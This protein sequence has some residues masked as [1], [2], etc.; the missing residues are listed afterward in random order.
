MFSSLTLLFL[1]AYVVKRVFIVPASL[2]HLPR[3]SV[4]ELLKSYVSREEES[5]RVR[6]LLLPFANATGERQ[7]RQKEPVVLVWAFG[8]WI[9]HVI[10]HE[11]GKKALQDRDWV[12]DLP[13]QSLLL[14]RFVGKKNLAFTIGEEWK[15]HSRVITHAFQG[16]PPISQFVKVFKRLQSHFPVS[17]DSKDGTTVLWDKWTEQIALD[18]L[19]KAVLGHDFEAISN[20]SSPVLKN[21]RYVMEHITEP[22]YI[23]IPI[24]DRLFPRKELVQS[25]DFIRERYQDI[26]SEKVA[27][28]EK[29]EK[30]G[31]GQEKEGVIDR[32]ISNPEFGRE[33]VLD[34]VSVLFIA[35]HETTAGGLSSIVYYLA[36]HPEFQSLARKEVDRVLSSSSDAE[37]DVDTLNALP[38]V[39][40]CIQESM[41]MNNPSNFTLPRLS[42]VPKNLGGYEIPAGTMM[43]F[44]V[45]AV[46]HL[47][48]TFDSP[49]HD[50]FDSTRF[51]IYPPSVDGSKQN[52]T[53]IPNSNAALA[54]QTAFFGL[55]IRQCPARHFAMW[56]L[57]TILTLLLKEYEWSL[58]EGSGHE[59]RVK[60][61]FSFGTNLN[62]PKG[63]EVVFKK[64]VI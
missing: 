16:S 33:D 47:S 46:H 49:P 37:L 36:K 58:P 29:G 52:G 4:W 28:L 17:S 32:M 15:K 14:W 35:G 12:R 8:L 55:G 2:A 60:N 45:S 56:E 41:R 19:G 6:R 38:T 64:R 42:A 23:F 61:A 18:V 27:A 63:L 44:N 7:G 48:G 20:P 1:F 51:L 34:N 24:L 57:R 59:G 54:S 22:P 31:V 5:Q 11:V 3:V 9:I 62:L 40:A 39:M 43:C 50:T 25:V 13:P 30:G 10:D 26:I 21:Y 53:P